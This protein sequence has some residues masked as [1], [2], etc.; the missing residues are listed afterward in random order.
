MHRQGNFIEQATVINR[1]AKPKKLYIKKKGRI[2][3]QT[4]SRLGCLPFLK[5]KPTSTFG[6]PPVA[7]YMKKKKER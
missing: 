2:R 6:V 5:G 7:T 4:I 1:L 3:R